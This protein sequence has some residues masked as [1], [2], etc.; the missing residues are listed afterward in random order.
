MSGKIIIPKGEDHQFFVEIKQPMSFAP[1]SLRKMNNATF[2]MFEYDGFTTVLTEPLAIVDVD[3]GVLVGNI[4]KSQ[5]SV[6]VPYLA[7]DADRAYLKSHYH[8]TISITYT[9]GT[10]SVNVYIDQVY[11][12]PE[13]S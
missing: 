4:S 1:Q 5:S 2:T 7:P 11:V 13:G 8:A 6:L 9:D 3:N 12:S 10:P